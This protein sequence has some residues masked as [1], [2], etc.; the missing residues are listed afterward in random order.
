MVPR[1]TVTGLRSAGSAIA[2]NSARLQRQK[3][4]EGSSLA[5]LAFD[6]DAAVM[7]FYDH[8]AMEHSDANAFF[9]GGAEGTK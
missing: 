8:F 2:R 7:G 1:V 3:D 4:P 6:L 5:Q 9:L